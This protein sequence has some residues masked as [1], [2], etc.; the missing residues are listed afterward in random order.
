MLEF[1]DIQHMVITRV[2]ALTGRYEFLSFRQP[3]Q[4]RAWLAAV[5]DKVS[6]VQQARDSL[7]REQRWVSIAFT[8]EGLRALGV[9]E[10]SLASFP[11][12]FR[13]G[14]VARAEVLGD[15][16]RN[17]PDQWAGNMASPALHAIAILF[18]RD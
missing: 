4:G 3:A 9:D 5:F 13:Q 7:E 12:E 10:K 17:S 16:G 18:A 8:W 6:S 14:M 11:E 15:T 1:D 2:P